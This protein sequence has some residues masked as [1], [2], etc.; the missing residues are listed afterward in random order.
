MMLSI[1]CLL[2][3]AVSF[4]VVQS[5]QAQYKIGD[6]LIVIS[7]A[8]ITSDGVVQQ[9]LGRGQDVRV[10]DI[11]LDQLRVKNLAAGWISQD[12]VRTPAVA[13]GVFTDQ[14]TLN[15]LDA[16]A[17]YARGITQ[18]NL[19]QYDLAIADF[20]EAIRLAPLQACAYIG[21]G[22]C[23]ANTANPA[24]AILDYTEAIRLD[25]SSAI[26]F[27]NRAKAWN[28][29]GEFAQAIADANAAIGIAPNY[30]N[31][32]SAR[33]VAFAATKQ[34]AEAFLD[35][36]RIAEISPVGVSGYNDVAWLL[37][38]SP[39]ITIRD[40]KRAV[41]FAMKAS[42]LTNELDGGVLDTLAIAWAEAAD[43]TKAVA[44]EQKALAVC[45]DRDRLD[46]EEHLKLFQASKTLLSA[47]PANSGL[48]IT[49]L[50]SKQ[51]IS[52]LRQPCLNGICPIPGVAAK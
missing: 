46:F 3:L 42:S 44:L 14:I 19:N 30:A 34:F 38:M 52:N 43:F 40:G 6:R 51:V 47:Q 35:C 11:N 16:G 23:W 1:R 48:R 41:E 17:F 7:Q 37:A 20:T 39:D 10:D 33:S 24:K 50:N 8:A 26:A 36:D 18:E 5:A 9:T 12:L 21:R 49:V 32:Y 29:T 4:V 28:T 45:S 27:A 25:P 15:P 2:A 31:A 13:V 22:N